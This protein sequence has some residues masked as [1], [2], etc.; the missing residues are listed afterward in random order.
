MGEARVMKSHH[1][2]RI[3]SRNEAGKMEYWGLKSILDG[4]RLGGG[5]GIRVQ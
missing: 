5:S 2:L 4:D 1:R 3:P